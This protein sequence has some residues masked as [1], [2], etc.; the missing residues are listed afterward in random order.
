M[1]LLEVEIVLG[2]I[3]YGGVGCGRLPGPY[4]DRD[5]RRANLSLPTD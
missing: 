3:G 4:H 2:R 1:A 5:A